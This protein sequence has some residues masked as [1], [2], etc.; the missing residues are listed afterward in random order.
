MSGLH[1]CLD[2]ALLMQDHNHKALLLDQF[3]DRQKTATGRDSLL[4]QFRTSQSDPVA[5]AA[6]TVAFG[7]VTHLSLAQ[8]QL[9]HR[10]RGCR[11]EGKPIRY[12]AI[13]LLLEDGR[14][15]AQAVKISI[16]NLLPASAPMTQVLSLV[17]SGTRLASK[18]PYYKTYADS[19]SGIRVD[20]PADVVFLDGKDE[21]QQ[22]RQSYSFNQ[23][24][25]YGNQAFRSIKG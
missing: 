2:K 9:D 20:N 12:T 15:R 22:R 13:Q 24:K 18:D 17:P 8:L 10:H 25:E 21:P 4:W 7:E 6:S 14:N 23:I 5:S 1:G 3:T 19:S 11:I 16:Y